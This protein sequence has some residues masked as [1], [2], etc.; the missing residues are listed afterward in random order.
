L[1]PADWCAV[2]DV[3]LINAAGAAVV[4]PVAL[5]FG[6]LIQIA[7]PAPLAGWHSL[8]NECPETRFIRLAGLVRC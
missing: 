5:F 2:Y 6:G 7:V 3:N 8:R 1:A 4:I